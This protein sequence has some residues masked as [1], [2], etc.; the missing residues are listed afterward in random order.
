MDRKDFIRV[1]FLSALILL[2]LVALHAQDPVGLTPS[3]DDAED[4]GKEPSYS[5]LK[6]GPEVPMTLQERAYTSPIWYTL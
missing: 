6:M 2:C 4:I 1:V 3:S 5:P